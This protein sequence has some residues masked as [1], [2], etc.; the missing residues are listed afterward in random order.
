[1]MHRLVLIVHGWPWFSQLGSLE[2]PCNMAA[3]FF[4]SPRGRGANGSHTLSPLQSL[5]SQR[6]ADSLRE[7]ATCGCE[8]RGGPSGR[9][10]W[11][12]L[13]PPKIPLSTS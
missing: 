9:L 1:M 13:C 3:G 4:Q 11:A 2:R 6:P 5:P 7:E 12:E 8:F 10:L